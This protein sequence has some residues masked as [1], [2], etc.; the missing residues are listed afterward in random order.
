MLSDLEQTNFFS[1]DPYFSLGEYLISTSQNLEYGNG[2]SIK[3][4]EQYMTLQDKDGKVYG[5]T[6]PRHTFIPSSVIYSSKARYDGQTPSS[7]R[8]N[9]NHHRHHD[10]SR[11]ELYP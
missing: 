2:L 10:D 7:H 4:G 5:V 9:L 6:R 8:P 3:M 11:V 1:Y